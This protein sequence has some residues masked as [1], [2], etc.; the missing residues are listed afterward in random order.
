MRRKWNAGEDKGRRSVG[1]GGRSSGVCR[2]E[3]RKRRRGVTAE[4]EEF[5]AVYG[6]GGNALWGK[7]KQVALGSKMI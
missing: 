7:R 6:G 5:W 1:W 4:A 3:G 2:K